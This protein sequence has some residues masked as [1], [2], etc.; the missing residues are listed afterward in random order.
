MRAKE[1][2]QKYLE[3]ATRMMIK[4]TVFWDVQSMILDLAS[5]LRVRRSVGRSNKAVVAA[6]L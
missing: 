6:A 2:K 1:Y 5:E 3:F 4:I